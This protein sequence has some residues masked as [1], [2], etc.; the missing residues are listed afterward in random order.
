MRSAHEVRMMLRWT[1]SSSA[2]ELIYL[3]EV[4]MA[5]F[6]LDAA[7]VLVFSDEDIVEFRYVYAELGYETLKSCGE[8]GRSSQE[9][10]RVVLEV[11]IKPR[12]EAEKQSSI[13]AISAFNKAVVLRM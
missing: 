1:A 5:S 7:A 6:G 10:E 13:K 11:K 2:E 3:L 9:I 4:L 8:R 12:H